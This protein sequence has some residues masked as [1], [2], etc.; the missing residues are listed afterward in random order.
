MDE[1]GPVFLCKCIL[2][3]KTRE[4]ILISLGFLP[5]SRFSSE[6]FRSISIFLSPCVADVWFICSSRSFWL[7]SLFVAHFTLM[8]Y[9]SCMVWLIIKTATANTNRESVLHKHGYGYAAYVCSSARKLRQCWMTNYTILFVRSSIHSFI[10]SFSHVPKLIAMSLCPCC[11][12]FK[13]DT[14]CCCCC[15]CCLTLFSWPGVDKVSRPL[16]IGVFVVAMSTIFSFLCIVQVLSES[17]ASFAIFLHL[18]PWM[19]F[20][21]LCTQNHCCCRRRYSLCLFGPWR[22]FPLHAFE[23]FKYLFVCSFLFLH[24]SNIAPR[25]KV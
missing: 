23:S 8:V 25:V 19:S 10:Y 14:T 13:C 16:A 6:N 9:I 11:W 20:I 7:S 2:L 21:W 15:Y 5:S 12:F 22:C 3:G 1:P 17:D 18:S 24:L 4:L